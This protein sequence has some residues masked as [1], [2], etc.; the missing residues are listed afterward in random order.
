[1]PLAA[2]LGGGSLQIV[3]CAQP[4]PADPLESNLRLTAQEMNQKLILTPADQ[5]RVKSVLNSVAGDHPPV[6]SPFMAVGPVRWSDVATSTYYACN[7]VEMAVT[8]TI[9]DES[10]FTFHLKTVDDRPGRLLISRVEDDRMYT[11]EA[12]V[13][14]FEDDD[15]LARRLIAAFDRHMRLFGAKR[16]LA[17]GDD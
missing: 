14:R 16:S 10:S 6:D 4:P 11:A 7:D 5:E 2:I 3:G 9:E 8:R 15:E 13:G 1:M 12:V 17:E